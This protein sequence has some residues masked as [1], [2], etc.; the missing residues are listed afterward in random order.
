MGWYL[1]NRANIVLW[2]LQTGT[3][4]TSAS[5]YIHTHTHTHTQSRTHIHTCINAYK[6]SI[7]M[8]FILT[9][10]IINLIYH[11]LLSMVL[12]PPPYF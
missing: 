11:T 8:K 2:P 1:K 7:S 6:W 9:P 10:D 4:T 3:Y 5:V 12:R